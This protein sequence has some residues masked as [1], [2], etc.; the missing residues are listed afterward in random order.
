MTIPSEKDLIAAAC[1][2]GHRV[3]RWNPKMAPYLYGKVQGVHVFDVFQTR[4]KLESVCIALARLIAEGKTLLLVSTKQQCADQVADIAKR[5]GLPMVTRRWTPGL[6]TNW[7]TISRRLRMYLD[8]QQSFQT[9]EVGKYT[10]KEQLKLRKLLTKLDS[11]LSGVAGMGGL[12]DAVF[13]VDAVRDRIAVLE[14]KIV[15]V[16]VYGICDSNA[17]P[18]LFTDFI[19]G[20]DDA[21]KSLQLFLTTIDAALQEAKA[22]RAA[23]AE[24]QRAPSSEAVAT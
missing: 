7:K 4:R 14:A 16:P 9:G 21:V 18:D 5:A 17:D 10:K 15:H 1:H 24:E 11:R 23:R 8:L 2:F 22:D 13:V 12:P 6:L 19:P 3:A 20:N